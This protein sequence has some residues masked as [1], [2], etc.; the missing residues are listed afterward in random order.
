MGLASKLAHNACSWNACASKLKG[1][2]VDGMLVHP[3]SHVNG[4]AWHG[5]ETQRMFMECLCLQTQRL[6]LMEWHGIETQ[7][8]LCMARQSHH[9]DKHS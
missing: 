4:L 2:L 1:L 8:M 6:M 3:T 5:I 7:R 9:T